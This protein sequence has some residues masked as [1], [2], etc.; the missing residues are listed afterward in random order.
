MYLG[1]PVR[2]PTF[3]VGSVIVEYVSYSGGANVDRVRVAMPQMLALDELAEPP[4]MS[5]ALVCWPA[6]TP[7]G[8]HAA[9]GG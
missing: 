5:V 3:D 2:W 7:F 4:P 9:N 8:G 6:K 1:P